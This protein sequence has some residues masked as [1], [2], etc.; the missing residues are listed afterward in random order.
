LALR[1]TQG[2]SH[3]L[4]LP[5]DAELLNLSIDGRTLNSK[6]EAGVLTLPI[7][8]GSQQ[9]LLSWREDQGIGLI[10]RSPALDLG[11]DAANISLKLA[12]PNDRWLLRL[13]GPA[14]GPAVL[15][16][17]G[18]I[19]LLLLGYGLGRS[20][21]ALLPI[22]A[23]M[24]L[25]LGF[26]TLS[27]VPL[28]IVAVAFIALDA[29]QRYLPGAWGKWRFDFAQLLLVV[30][31]AG[32]ASYGEY[33][34]LADRSSGVLP[35]ASAISL[36]M[37]AYKALMLAFALWLAWALIGWIKLAWRALISGTGWM[38]LRPEK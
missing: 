18:L 10:T 21:R 16:W 30:L 17:S 38:Q 2:G 8:P 29:R 19:V 20:G 6:P 33:A 3:A 13:A 37:W 22:G 24:L 31:S 12:L 32:S 14:V 9:V 35:T 25:V 5:A 27:Y 4:Q 15:Y 11:L 7:K 28:L 23:W 1:A 34:W 26:S 36:P